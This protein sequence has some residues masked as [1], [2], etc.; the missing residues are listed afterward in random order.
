MKRK[1]VTSDYDIKD[2]R[3][4]S[5]GKFEGE[6]V[7]APYFYDAYLNGMADDEGDRL[8]FDVTAEDRR[9]FPELKNVKR[10]FLSEDDNGFVYCET[11]ER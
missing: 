10:V 7:Y 1:D 6:A 4:S 9:E 5:P 11:E 3:I 2:G 8:V